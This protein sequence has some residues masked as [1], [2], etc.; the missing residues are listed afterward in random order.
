MSKFD[1]GLRASFVIAPIAAIFV[2][3][4]AGLR[5]GLDVVSTALPLAIRIRT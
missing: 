4:D 3:G 1:T 5:L 2:R